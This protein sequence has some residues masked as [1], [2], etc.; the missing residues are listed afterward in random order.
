MRRMEAERSNQSARAR[1]EPVRPD[2]IVGVRVIYNVTA[3]GPITIAAYV[4]A[5]GLPETPR[6]DPDFFGPG[7]RCLCYLSA[8]SHHDTL[9]QYKPRPLEPLPQRPVVRD[10]H[11]RPQVAGQG[12]FQFLD[13]S[14]R[15]V[16][17]MSPSQAS[18]DACCTWQI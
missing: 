8:P 9:L 15:E 2:E 1:P 13:Q 7:R 5:K 14:G 11:H 3:L 10:Q 12:L 17:S 18:T 6:R 16:L 4:A